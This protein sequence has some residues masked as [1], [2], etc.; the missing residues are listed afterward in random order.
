MGRGLRWIQTSSA[1]RQVLK[2]DNTYLNCIQCAFFAVM[3]YYQCLCYII[4]CYNS[5]FFSVVPISIH[6]AFDKV[7]FSLSQTVSVSLCY[8]HILNWYHKY[9]F[10]I[11]IVKL[12]QQKYMCKYICFSMTKFLDKRK[13]WFVDQESKVN[14]RFNAV[15]ST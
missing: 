1:L 11:Y 5:L 13:C 15:N 4:N 3:Y 2:W 9:W 10:S 8:G 12:N 7:I 6:A 14:K